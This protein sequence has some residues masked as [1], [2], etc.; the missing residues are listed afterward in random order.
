M[1]TPA[2]VRGVYPDGD[3]EFRER[4]ITEVRVGKDRIEIGFD[5]STFCSVE[6]GPITPVVGMTLRLYPGDMGSEVRGVFID[7]VCFRYSTPSQQDWKHRLWCAQKH[8]DDQAR[9]DLQIPNRDRRWAALPAQ[10]RARKQRFMAN[11]PE[12]RRDYET[13]ELFTCEEAF[14][15]ATAFSTHAEI[16]AWSLLDWE[17]QKA[18]L[19]SLGEGHSGNTFG[20][21][22]QL[23]MAYITNPEV[24][25]QAH[26][27]L[28]PLVGSDAY[29][30]TPKEATK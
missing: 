22:C 9:A 16:R 14:K 1:S 26:G 21:A 10:F 23:A 2:I 13:Y 4:Q 8:A 18:A 7:G 25:E 11:N 29:G 28:S 5:V 24:V 12:W 19:P 3:A 30:D 20:M 15:I 27:A 17:E 6:P